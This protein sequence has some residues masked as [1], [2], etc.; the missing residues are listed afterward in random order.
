MTDKIPFIFSMQ[1]GTPTTYGIED[2]PDE[3]DQVWTTGFYKSSVAGPRYLS[4]TNLDGDGQADTVNHGGPD[5]AALFYAAAHYPHW[6]AELARPD[7]PYGAFGENFTVAGL[8]EEDVC[9]GDTYT[10]G[11][12]RVQVS[13]PRGPCWKI[14]RRWR[15]AD[16][17]ARVLDSGRTGWYVRVL[18]EGMVEAGMPLALL[19]RPYPQWTIARVNDTLYRHGDADAMRALADCP[20]LAAVV[21][22]SLARRLARATKEKV[23]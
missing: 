18:Q 17:T 5:K 13:Q 10:I 15:I 6:H 7:L 1:V 21:R 4:R 11:D 22:Q 8:T 2:A 16:L 19:D 12:V 20:L 3:M 14:A 9:V 23:A